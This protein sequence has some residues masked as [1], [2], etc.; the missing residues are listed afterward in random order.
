M[1]LQQLRFFVAVYEDGSFSAAAERMNATQSG[2]STHVSHLEKR[3]GVSLFTRSSAGVTPT[4]A[5]RLFYREAVAVLAASA[6]AEDR[7]VGLSKSLVGDVRVGLMPTFTRAVLAPALLRFSAE[8][9]DVRVS[10]SEAYS[11]A[12]G[13]EVA[14]G[15][16]DFAVVPAFDTAGSLSGVPIGRDH[17]CLVQCAAPARPYRQDMTLRELGPLKIV[18]P[19]RANARRLRIET[20]LSVNGV[21]IAEMMELDSMH[22]TLDIIG[23]SDWVGILPG[24][25]CLPDLDGSRRRVTPL[26]AP[27]F[28]VTYIRITRRARPLTP[29]A[30]A[31]AAVLQAELDAALEVLPESLRADAAQR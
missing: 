11:G 4:E 18:L 15:R 14:E 25:L 7:L 8:H 24:I 31:F 1:K 22:G 30:E 5:G 23:R 19:G 3:Y 21:E 17:E 6:R 10:V 20:Y 2:L 26:T 27:E 28:D 29:A 16:L 12:L 9:P 13:T